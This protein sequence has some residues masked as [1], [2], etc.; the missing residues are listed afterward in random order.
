MLLKPGFRACRSLS[1]GFN[2]ITALILESGF[3]IFSITRMFTVTLCKLH[4]C[5]I[6]MRPKQNFS[7]QTTWS[8][9]AS[10]DRPLSEEP[11]PETYSLR[12]CS[13]CFVFFVFCRP[14]L[15]PN[16]VSVLTR[17][18]ERLVEK[19]WLSLSNKKSRRSLSRLWSLDFRLGYIILSYSVWKEKRSGKKWTPSWSGNYLE[20]FRVCWR[21]SKDEV[22]GI[23]YFSHLDVLFFVL[24][25]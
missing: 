25:L 24:S 8:A 5:A 21:M 10:R 4:G 1:P 20:A 23:V 14:L 16:G 2:N 15:Q 7:C 19:S 9:S 18:S 3:R 12:W 13:P 6:K 22:R 11:L 17:N